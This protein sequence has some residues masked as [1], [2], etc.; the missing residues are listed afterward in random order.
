MWK[1]IKGFEGFYQISEYGDVK[2]LKKK[3]SRNPLS[4]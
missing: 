4:L 2:S 1:D 3:R